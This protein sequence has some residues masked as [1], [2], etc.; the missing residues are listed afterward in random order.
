MYPGENRKVFA[1]VTPG[2]PD[3]LRV[4]TEGNVYAGCGDGVQVYSPSGTL[5]GKIYLGTT[6]ANF[7]FA[8]KG[9]MVILGEKNLYYATLAAEGSYVD[10]YL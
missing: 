9:R 6:S 4:D 8:G 2:V 5:L 10:D 3:G 1:F 7:Q